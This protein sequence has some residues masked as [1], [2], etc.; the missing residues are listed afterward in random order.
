MIKVFEDIAAIVSDSRLKLNDRGSQLHGATLEGPPLH[1]LK[2]LDRSALQ[3]LNLINDLYPAVS[4]FP[5]FKNSNLLFIGP[6]RLTQ[7]VYET[8]FSPTINKLSHR[9][10]HPQYR[11]NLIIL[12]VDH[13]LHLL[14]LLNPC[15]V[16]I[17][18]L[19][20]ILIVLIEFVVDVKIL[21][22]VDTVK[23]REFII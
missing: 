4:I 17:I 6:Q 11:G 21:V 10:F 13:N 15:P 23:L 20:F 19:S 8:D 7:P 14:F 16:F 9:P 22:E 18:I 5:D 3:H 2:E 12:M 1:Q